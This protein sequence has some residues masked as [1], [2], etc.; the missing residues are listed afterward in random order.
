MIRPGVR[1]GNLRRMA[2]TAL[3]AG[4][5]QSIRQYFTPVL[6]RRDSVIDDARQS[7]CS[8]FSYRPTNSYR[9]KAQRETKVDYTCLAKFVMERVREGEQ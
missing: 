2:V 4:L 7:G 9:A 6:R 8:I 3:R 5:Q 1:V